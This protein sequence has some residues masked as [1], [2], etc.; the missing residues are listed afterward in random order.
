M[1]IRLNMVIYVVGTH[2]NHFG[3]QVKIQPGQTVS[4]FKTSYIVLYC[5]WEK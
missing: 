1:V 3:K 5:I 2:C 4:D